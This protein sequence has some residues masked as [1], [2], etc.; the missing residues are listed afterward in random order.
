MP[1]K[2]EV[3]CAAC[4]KSKSIKWWELAHSKTKLFYCNHRCFGDWLSKN[5][6]GKDNQFYGKKHNPESLKRMTG[7]NHWNYGNRTSP[8]HARPKTNRKPTLIDNK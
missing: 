2:I 1:E 3:Y 4:G 7:E 6:Q 5:K 8:R